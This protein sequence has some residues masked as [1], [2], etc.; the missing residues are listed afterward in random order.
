[1]TAGQSACK[2]TH[3]AEVC[4][5]MP[6][7]Q[8]AAPGTE[9]LYDYGREYWRTVRHSLRDLGACKK[10]VANAIAKPAAWKEERRG[11]VAKIQR[12]EREV[13]KLVRRPGCDRGS[14][15]AAESTWQLSPCHSCPHTQA[16]ADARRFVWW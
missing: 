1:M 16:R 14:R 3:H 8:C 4:D 11:L 9:V 13:R 5:P 7:V 15:F 2:R 12:L 6:H 10:A